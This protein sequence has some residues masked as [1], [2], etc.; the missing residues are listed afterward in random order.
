[1]NQLEQLK[2]FTTVVADTGDFQ[3]IKAYT[4]QDA[5]TNPS[6]ILKTGRCWKKPWPI[7]PTGRS[8]MSST[9]C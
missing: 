6:L 8:M 1:M 9:V 7:R 2:Q 5:T 4:P 3:S